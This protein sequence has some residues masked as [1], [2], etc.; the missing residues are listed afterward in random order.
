MTI[1][2][3]Q[4]RLKRYLL[5]HLGCCPVPWHFGQT[6]CAYLNTNP[7]LLGLFLHREQVTY[8]LSLN[9]SR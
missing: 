1:G 5:P 2:W 9:D 7:F 8:G 3:S 4:R 6:R